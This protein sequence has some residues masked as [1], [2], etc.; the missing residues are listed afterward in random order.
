M[1]SSLPGYLQLGLSC[2]LSWRTMCSR[3]KLG[4]CSLSHLL[5]DERSSRSAKLIDLGSFLFWNCLGLQGVLWWWTRQFT[6]L[7]IFPRLQCILKS[8][9]EGQTQ[10]HSRLMTNHPSTLKL[11]LHWNLMPFHLFSPW[12][13]RKQRCDITRLRCSIISSSVVLLEKGNMFSKP[14]ATVTC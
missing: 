10:I 9:W 3:G 4:K 8:L 7:L 12:S 13:F 11:W 6:F 2:C 14:S 1:Q 5:M